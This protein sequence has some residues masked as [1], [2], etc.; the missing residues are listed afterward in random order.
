MVDAPVLEVEPIA[1]KRFETMLVVEAACIEKR[2]EGDEEPTPTSELKKALPPTFSVE[3]SVVEPVTVRAEVVA[4][5][6]E[7]KPPLTA[8]KIPPIVEDA[9]MESEPE[10]VALPKKLLP[11]ELKALLTVVEP[12]MKRL[13]ALSSVNNVVVAAVA[14]VEAIA[15]RYWLCDVDAARIERSA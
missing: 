13:P 6:S 14:E 7:T 10:V 12:K 4:L 11:R 3:F 1:N 2:A 8:L 5:V 9:E 15:N